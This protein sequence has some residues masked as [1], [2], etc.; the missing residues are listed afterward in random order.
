MSATTNNPTPFLFVAVNPAGGKKFGMRAA[1]TEAALQDSLR[2]DRLLLLRA[3][4]T[5]QWAAP[6]DALSLPLKD[7]TALNEQ[8]SHLLKRGVPLVDALQVAA[9][10]VSAKARV[11]AARLRELVSAGAS[12]SNACEQVGGFDPVS[13]AVYRA[14]ERT[15]DLGDAAMRLAAASRRRLAIGQKAVTLMI[16]PAVVLTISIIVS[17]VMLIVVVPLIG[18]AL[19]DANIDLPWYS[20][21]VIGSGQWMRANL[22]IVGGVALAAIV[23]LILG[24]KIIVGLVLT[25][26]RRLPAIARLQVSIEA[27][28]FF[29]IMG[30]LVRTGVPVADA[31]GIA[32]NTVSAA[33][34]RGQLETMRRRLV[35][36]GLFRNLV[37]EV[38]ELPL[39]TRRLLIAAERSGDLETAFDA[40]AA[41]M[42]D[43]VARRSDR[44]MALLEPLLIVLM[45]SV[46]GTLLV[47][48]ML[49]MMSAMRGAE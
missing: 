2:R 13:I 29:A 4:K 35:E 10:V 42:G 33:K 30:A 25:L 17:A 7:Q 3:W 28:R 44:L 45:F 41:D 12:F 18:K 36:G 47:S 27:A 49:P 32:G 16:Y 8:L 46:I 26:S 43:D 34:L 19:Q 38:D 21:I 9:S 37:E 40:M 23:G 20:Q 48:I 15:G 6:A 22:A 14:A 5:P 11:K 39:A 24:R 1:V 31:L